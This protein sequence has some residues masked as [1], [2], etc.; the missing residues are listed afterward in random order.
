MAMEM[1]YLGLR[2]GINGAVDG[3]NVGGA[4]GGVE[5]GNMDTDGATVNG[6]AVGI[7]GAAV[8]GVEVGDIDGDNVGIDGAFVGIDGANVDGTA[9]DGTDVEG[10]TVGGTVVEGEYVGATLNILDSKY[11]CIIRYREIVPWN[12][13][14]NGDDFPHPSTFAFGYVVV[15]RTIKPTVTWLIEGC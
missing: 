6:A 5:V 7:D 12:I 13:S 11:E 3:A 9:I 2:V 10:A 15:A 14:G 8:D 4:D 1:Q